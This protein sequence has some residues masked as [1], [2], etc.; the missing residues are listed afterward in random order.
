LDEVLK[1]GNTDYFKSAA[2]QRFGHTYTMAMKSIRGF[3]ESKAETDD[4]QCITL[5]TQNGW[6]EDQP[7]WAEMIADYKRVNQKATGQEA[8]AIYQKLP[9]YLQVFKN[10]YLRLQNLTSH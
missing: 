3:R 7:Q 1:Q 5:A 10:L 6:T 4:E 9:R 2:L 8:E